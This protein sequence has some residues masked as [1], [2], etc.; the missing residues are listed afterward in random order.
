[1]LQE[2]IYIRHVGWI[3]HRTW[4][5]YD[6]SALAYRYKYDDS[7]WGV[8]LLLENW[9]GG[10]RYL[11]RIMSGFNTRSI[12]LLV[13]CDVSLIRTFWTK[14]NEKYPVKTLAIR[15]TYGITSLPKFTGITC[16]GSYK[17][18]ECNNQPEIWSIHDYCYDYVYLIPTCIDCAL[19]WENENW[20]GISM[21]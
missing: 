4:P 7:S 12:E 17:K 9:G 15:G 11:D 5:I 8:I 13:D 18:D 20:K 3:K 2:E 10:T 21:E 14:I 19:V 1:M 6:E 16:A